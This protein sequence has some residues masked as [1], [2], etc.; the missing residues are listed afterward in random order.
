VREGI[1]NW[2]GHDCSLTPS[3]AWPPRHPQQQ[4]ERGRR[5]VLLTTL[6]ALMLAVAI[7][8]AVAARINSRA[9]PDTYRGSQANLLHDIRLALRTDAE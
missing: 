2:R 6:A 7:V 8:L 4:R 9:G 1:E 5:V 3:R